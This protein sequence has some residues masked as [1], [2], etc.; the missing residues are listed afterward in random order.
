MMYFSE[1]VNLLKPQLF[2]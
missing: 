1:N 2:I